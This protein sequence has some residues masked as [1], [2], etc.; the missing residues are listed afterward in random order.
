[1]TSPTSA[2]AELLRRA[3]QVGLEAARAAGDIL[4]QR[5]D[6]IR[7]VR[8]KGLVDIVTDVDLQSEHEVC[9]LILD[10]FPSHSILGE[11]GGSRAGDP[12]YR[13]IVDPL[14][15][16]TNYAHGFPFFCVSI[17]F[18]VDGQLQLGVVYAPSLQEL[19]IGERGHGATLNGQPISVSAVDMLT[20]ALLAT[21]FPYERE[22]FPR[23]LKS[24]EA[25][26][27]ASQAVRRAGSAALDLCYVACGRL[28][29]YWEH[30]VKAW[31][32]AGGALIVAEAGGQ[33][34][35]TDGSSFDVDA[36]QVL[37][38]NQLLHPGLVEI[39]MHL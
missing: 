32:L 39:L 19:F 21:G 24:F 14:D 20:N 6:S 34:S 2:D 18:E 4:R 33:L 13:W 17:G 37:A 10:A 25:V 26:S 36:N 29:G 9:S 27:L 3:R 1:V 7:E 38:S 12:R 8:H 5:I 35:R 16:T 28:D 11:E 23:A 30:R 22:D 15:G 31:D